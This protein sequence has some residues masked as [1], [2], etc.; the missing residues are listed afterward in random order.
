[1]SENVTPDLS[2][3]IPPAPEHAPQ[4]APQPA[5]PQA[6][7]QQPGYQQQ[8]APQPQYQP[9]PQVRWTGI[10]SPQKEKWVAVVL[11]FFLGALGLHKFYLGYKTEGIIMLVVALAGSI[12]LGL[13][14]VVMSIIAIIEAV[15]YVIL[16][17]EDFERT[18]VYGSKSWF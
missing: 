17:Q 8:Y 18:Y 11:A 10:G 6:P 9:A 13:G 12:C 1:M 5:E 2:Q 16:T 3:R 14:Y 4:Y 15:K 7:Y